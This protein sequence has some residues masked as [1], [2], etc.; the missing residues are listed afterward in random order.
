M[1]LLRTHGGRNISHCGHDRPDGDVEGAAWG[2]EQ[3]SLGM[4]ETRGLLFLPP[5]SHS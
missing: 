1:P 4:V 5:P 3:A 2:R